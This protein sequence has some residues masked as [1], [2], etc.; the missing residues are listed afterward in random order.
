[1]K[2]FASVKFYACYEFLL[3]SSQNRMRTNEG[4]DGRKDSAEPTVFPR[5]SDHQP[6]PFLKI[7]IFTQ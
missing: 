4:T 5:W 7:L 6:V 2:D 1:M 3:S